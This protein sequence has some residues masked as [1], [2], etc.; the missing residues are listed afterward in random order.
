MEEQKQKQIGAFYTPD[1]L[2][3]A[4]LEAIDYNPEADYKKSILDPACGDGQFLVK[5]SE[6]ICQLKEKENIIDGLY[7]LFGYD[8]D[9]NAVRKT[10]E[11]LDNVISKYKP[12]LSGFINWAV[13]KK[14]SLS[15]TKHRSYDIIIGNPPF[16]RIQEMTEA[17]KAVVAQYEFCSY[18]SYDLYLAFVELGIKLL[19]ENGVLAFILPNSFM[20]TS[21]AKI[22]REYIVKNNMIGKIINYGSLE[23]FKNVGTYISILVLR[24]HNNKT[25]WIYEDREMQKQLYI[26]S[27]YW[28]SDFVK[29]TGKNHVLLSDIADIHV[30]ITTLADKIFIVKK[31]EEKDGNIKIKNGCGI[32]HWIESNILKLCIK[33]SR[34]ESDDDFLKDPEYIIFPYKMLN[35]K[36]HIIYEE[37]MKCEYPLAYA[38]FEAYKDRL[39][40]RDRGKGESKYPTWYA[41]GRHQ[42]LEEVWGPKIVVPPIIKKPNFRISLL[43]DCGL[44][45]GYFIK[46]KTKNIDMHH[47]LSN[48]NSERMHDWLITNS[49][50]F[51]G[52]YRACNKTLLKDYPIYM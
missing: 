40:A 27:G 25:F 47:I 43:E 3:D 44:Y 41:L 34:F 26:P 30:G 19:K 24:K 35:G 4:V 1:E 36:F 15:I 8:I 2:V 29:H 17:Q 5:I 46:P 38:Y 49:R 39:L 11:R 21:S 51:R 45:A 12:E 48:L 22:M 20:Y 52:G 33:A 7:N 10:K 32:E 23:K 9:E 18:G 31:T 28:L 37:E 14:D 50:P 6:K 16:V 13:Y 42:N